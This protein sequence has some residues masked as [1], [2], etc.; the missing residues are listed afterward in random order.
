MWE[1]IFDWLEDLF[2]KIL[3]NPIRNIVILIVSGYIAYAMGEYLFTSF[4]LLTLGG[5]I[6][7]CIKGLTKIVD[8]P[9]RTVVWGV[10]FTIGAVAVNMISE[11]LIPAYDGNNIVSLISV[12]I[13]GYVILSFYLKSQEL[14]NS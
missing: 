8:K 14:K 2:K 11:N 12:L 6:F 4:G 10:G 3:D 1:F 7:A 9:E 5:Y 13:I